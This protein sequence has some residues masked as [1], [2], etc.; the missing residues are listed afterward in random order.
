MKRLRTTTAQNP[1][2]PPVHD[3]TPD[4]P[5]LPLGSRVAH[6][7]WQTALAGSAG[8]MVERALVWGGHLFPYRSWPGQGAAIGEIARRKAGQSLIATLAG[9][10]R[11]VVPAIPEGVGLYMT[12]TYVERETVRLFQRFW[13][14]GQIFFDVG[15]NMG[16]YTF[17]A[18]RACG[19]TGH[20]H[21]F[22]PQTALVAHLERSAALNTSGAAVTITYAAVCDDHDGHAVLYH[23]ADREGTGIPSLLMHG[24]LD[25]TSGVRVPTVSIDGY[26]QAN[27]IGRIDAM[28][29]DVEGAEMGVLNGMRETF[30]RSPPELIVLEVLPASL[31]FQN[32]SGGASLPQAASAALPGGVLARLAQHGYQA[33]PIHPDG[34]LGA[35]C[36]VD[37]LAGLAWSL[38]LAFVRPGMSSARPEL[39]APPDRSTPVSG[40]P[41]AGAGAV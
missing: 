6:R 21:A 22:E 27:R 4:D 3:P 29:I 20:V 17:L 35:P 30:Q 37:D 18:A 40:V 2:P 31:S 32:I 41:E 15:A 11:I 14:P 19:R 34:R 8:P 9:G 24:W 39:F 1:P 7:V 13:R 28:K 26:C 36:T 5:A 25:P 38:N 16:L 10:V 33:R 23:G 12:G